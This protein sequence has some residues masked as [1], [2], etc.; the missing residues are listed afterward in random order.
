VVGAN[1]VVHAVYTIPKRFEAVATVTGKKRHQ[2]KLSV[3][4]HQADVMLAI[5]NPGQLARGADTPGMMT[6]YPAFKKFETQSQHQ[7]NNLKIKRC[8][9][10]RMSDHAMAAAAPPPPPPPRGAATVA[11]EKLHVRMGLET[12]KKVSSR[13]FLKQMR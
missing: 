10:A 13:S 2:L 3:Q 5:S 11:I 7:D 8:H 4:R 1:S 9:P 6:I 12:N